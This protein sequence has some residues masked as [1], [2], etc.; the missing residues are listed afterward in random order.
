MTDRLPALIRELVE[1]RRIPEKPSGIPRNLKVDILPD[2]ATV[3]MGVRRCGK[4][5]LMSQWIADLRSR[6]VPR[7]NIL[8]LDFFDERLAGFGKNDFQLIVEAF[9][10]ERGKDDGT[11]IHA[12]FDELQETDGWEGFVHRV[13]Q[14]LGWQVYIT[15][16]SSRML[17]KEIATRMRGRSLSHELFPFSFS[18]YLLA[19]GLPTA[20]D[21]EESRALIARACE[22]FLV[23]GGFPESVGIEERTRVK[24]HQEYFSAV[25]QRDLILRNDAAHPAAVRDLAL[26]LM[27]DNA[28]LHSTNRLTA[29]LQT[30]GHPATKAFVGSCLEWMHD[31]YLFFPVP[32]FSRSAA[33][34]QANPR[35]WYCV[36]TGM[37]HSVAS[38]FTQDHG[39]TLEAAVF[40]AL[41]RRGLEIFY[42]RTKSAKEVDFAYK[43]EDGRLRLIQVCWDMGNAQTREREVSAL[44]EAMEELK[45]HEAII[46]TEAISERLE[47]G[48]R[49]VDAVPAWRFL[50]ES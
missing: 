7:K 6:G 36:D 31:A 46:V 35:K 5:T 38:R 34:R 47:I 50:L 40:L 3:L 32:I 18:E 26:R 2:K 49:R 45:P 44:G 13:Q 24:L 41:R 14:S 21:S 10:A 37:A 12:F 8:H 27:Q 4:S 39:R 19:A 23:E 1:T 22:R 43:G 28:C 30:S 9:L 48:G 20:P 25:L 16:S 11:G 15:G 17:S 42:H 33:K 29:A